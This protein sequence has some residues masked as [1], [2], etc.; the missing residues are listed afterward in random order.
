M[1]PA[2]A[3]FADSSNTR[4]KEVSVKD[5]DF[6]DEV[7]LRIQPGEVVEMGDTIIITIANGEFDEDD[8]NEANDNN[9]GI[10]NYQYK[11]GDKTYKDL[12]SD[13]QGME[14]SFTSDWTS[15]E[16]T[17]FLTSSKKTQREK[18]RLS[19]SLFQKLTLVRTATVMVN[20][21]TKSQCLSQ[22]TVQAT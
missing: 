8:M 13:Y 17:S 14:G 16:L 5:G 22:L 18:S 20:H 1:V 9:L 7:F 11:L 19:S 6:N 15:T 3:A 21:Y 2:T 4:S 10:D 12:K